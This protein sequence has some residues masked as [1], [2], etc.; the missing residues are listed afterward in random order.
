M[1]T[2]S[3]SPLFRSVVRALVLYRATKVR[4][5]EKPCEI[6]Q[7][8]LTLLRLSCLQVTG[9]KCFPRSL[10]QPTATLD[11]RAYVLALMFNIEVFSFRLSQTAVIS[12]NLNC[13]MAL[14]CR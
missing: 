10:L 12:L 7:L 13:V 14:L 2:A 6:F 4:F 1:T 3:E 5:S 9:T 11:S 8:Y